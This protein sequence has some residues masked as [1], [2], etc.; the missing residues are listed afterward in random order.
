MPVVIVGAGQA[1]LAVSHE[2]RALGVEHTVLE[3]GRVA[4][5]WRGRWDTFCLVTPNW[6]VQLPG[7]E[8]DG[9]DPDG[10]MPRDEIVAHLERKVIEPTGPRHAVRR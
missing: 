5:T 4:N 9:A 7:G 1:G 2:L 10:Y 3:R 8:Y 6:T